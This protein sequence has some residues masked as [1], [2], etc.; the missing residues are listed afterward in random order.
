VHW[1]STAVKQLLEHRGIRE[2]LGL[3]VTERRVV[4]QPLRQP[5]PEKPP[6]RHVRPRNPERFAHRRQPAP[7]KHQRELD[8]HSRIDP[9]AARTTRPIKRPGGL[10][11]VTPID[12]RL[13]PTQIIISRDKIVQ[14][15]HLDLARLLPRAD[16]ERRECHTHSVPVTP[17]E[18]STRS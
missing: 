1:R 9:M 13:D 16:R 6:N 14:T 11:N 18:T 12:Q 3:R 2:A 4:R 17:D 15:N 10:T 5:E 8:Q 7:G